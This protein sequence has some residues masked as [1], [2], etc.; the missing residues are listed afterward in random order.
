[1]VIN[2]VTFPREIRGAL[3]L[4]YR[5]NAALGHAGTL[6]GQ[7]GKRWGHFLLEGL[8]GISIF[9]NAE[10]KLRGKEVPANASFDLPPAL[11]WGLSVNF[12]YFP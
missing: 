3:R 2:A 1:L 10:D 4:G 6:G 5:Y 7:L 8:W 11:G 12:M 9:P